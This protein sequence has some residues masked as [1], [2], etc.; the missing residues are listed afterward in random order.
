MREKNIKALVGD[1]INDI[2]D[3]VAFGQE[4]DRLG[5]NYKFFSDIDET[6]ALSSVLIILNEQSKYEREAN[7]FVHKVISDRIPIIA[8]Y[9]DISDNKD[10]HDSISFTEN[11]VRLWNKIPAF[12]DERYM[13]AT[14]HIPLCNLKLIIKRND[15]IKGTKLDPSDYYLL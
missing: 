12:A 4:L 14:V 15:F 10:I 13:V 7:V 11:V 9:T 8:I 1:V 5:V 2:E 3:V 6:T